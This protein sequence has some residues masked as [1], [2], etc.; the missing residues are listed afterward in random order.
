MEL[1]FQ[2]EDLF[3]AKSNNRISIPLLC[4]IL[5]PAMTM[6]NMSMDAAGHDQQKEPANVNNLAPVVGFFLCWKWNGSVSTL[7]AGGK[8]KREK[9][10]VRETQP[11]AVMLRNKAKT[12]TLRIKRGRSKQPHAISQIRG[13]YGYRAVESGSGG[14]GEYR[15]R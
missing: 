5:R 10:N 15:F 3:T 8:G 14:G 1:K 2:V 7:A 9:A 12:S 11:L 13:S 4:L 6:T